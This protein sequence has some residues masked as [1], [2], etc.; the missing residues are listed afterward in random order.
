MSIH[1][2]YLTIGELFGRSYIFRVPRY[3]RGYAWEDEETDD[4]LRDITNCYNARIDGKQRE[5]FFGGIVAVKH[6]EV[7]SAGHHCELID[8][9]QRIATVVL[10]AS[11]LATQFDQIEN[12][13]KLK[14]DSANKSLARAFSDQI[15]KTYLEFEDVINRKPQDINRLELSSP[16][17]PFFSELIQSTEIPQCPPDGER[18][19]HIRLWSAYSKL[20]NDLKETIDQLNSFD[21]QIESLVVVRDILLNDFTVINIVADQESEAYRIFQVL[22]N[23]GTKLTEGD[24]LR[25]STLEML[26]IPQ[27]KNKHE[28]AAVIWDDILQY[29]PGYTHDF[30]GWHFASTQGYRA[31]KSSLF[32]EF[33]DEI[34]PLHNT[35]PLSKTAA[36]DVVLGIKKIQKSNTLCRQLLDGDWP[37]IN[38]KASRWDIDRL[39]LLVRTL[40]HTACIPLLLAAAELDENKFVEVVSLTERFSF[41]YKLICKLHLTSLQNIYHEHALEMRSNPQK[42]KVS[43]LRKAYKDLLEKKSSDALFSTSLS[44]S[45]SYKQSSGN[46]L[47]KYFLSTLEHYWRWNEDGAHGHPKCKDKT[48]VF[49]LAS[50]TIEHIYPRKPKLKNSKESLGPLANKLGNLTLLGQEDNNAIGNKS[51]NDKKSYLKKSS[52]KLNQVISNEST[53]GEKQIEDREHQLIQ[54]A[55]SVFS[56]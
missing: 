12:A 52:L 41:R 56:M 26:G 28:T 48:R 22:N 42:Y 14:K 20:Y 6:D 54:L 27:L 33:I 4:F 18:Q 15:K 3:Q 50:M 45:L 21:E 34:F 9:Q 37:Y 17:Q 31:G 5:H 7:G 32:D 35:T 44:E 19:S 53:W 23:R 24:L 46:K 29:D 10:L 49:D 47:L 1:P 2:D 55:L 30:F 16:D 38:G 13:A 39:Q 43:A 25:A 51:F 40:N 11:C 36:E 8:G